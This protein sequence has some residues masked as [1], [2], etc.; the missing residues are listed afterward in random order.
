MKIGYRTRKSPCYVRTTQRT[1]GDRSSVGPL[2]GLQGV[3]TP[4]LPTNQRFGSVP[5]RSRRR[6]QSE[7][8]L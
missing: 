7:T 8:E 3:D 6:G 2:L 5:G 4:V 1:L